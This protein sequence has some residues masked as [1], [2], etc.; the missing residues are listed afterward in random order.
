MT[1][2][3]GKNTCEA[4][5]IA[6]AIRLQVERRS[7]ELLLFKASGMP[8]GSNARENAQSRS[9]VKAIRNTELVEEQPPTDNGCPLYSPGEWPIPIAFDAE[10][11]RDAL[12]MQ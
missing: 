2:S 3:Q 1:R 5:E 7:G 12:I 9:V 4:P 10:F 8:Y 6:A 11:L